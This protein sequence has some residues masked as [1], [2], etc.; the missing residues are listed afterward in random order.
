MRLAG[1][2][3]SM[4]G[5]GRAWPGAVTDTRQARVV[6]TDGYILYGA[7][8]LGTERGAMP[9]AVAFGECWHGDCSWYLA[10]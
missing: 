2:F 1:V 8:S 5:A 10:K 4:P 3:Q 6:R 7:S 9:C